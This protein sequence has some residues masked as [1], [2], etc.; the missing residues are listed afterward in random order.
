MGL[1]PTPPSL[2]LFGL[3]LVVCLGT[4]F[5][6]GYQLMVLNPT[7]DAVAAFV[8][9]SFS[10]RYGYALSDQACSFLRPGG[11]EEW[12]LRGWRTCGASS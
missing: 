6:Y 1:L 12:G 10:D 11:G 8:N 5:H 3:G 2:N 4:N 9:T 7:K